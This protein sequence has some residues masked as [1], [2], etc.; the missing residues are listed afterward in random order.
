[1]G[2]DELGALLPKDCTALML[3]WFIISGRE[4]LSLKDFGVKICFFNE[5]LRVSDVITVHVPLTSETYHMISFKEFE[6]MKRGVYIINTARGAV[7]DEKA[8]YE[9][10][11]S[12]KVAGQL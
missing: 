11:V 5:L 3:I 6:L 1:L 2:L 12:G 10:L 8:L 4:T 7:I 9:A